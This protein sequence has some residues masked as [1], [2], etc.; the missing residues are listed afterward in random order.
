MED[1]VKVI[2]LVGRSTGGIG[3]HVAQLS[4]DLRE[5]GVDVLVVTHPL[6]AEHFDLAPVALC[7]PGSA[8]MVHSLADLRALRR[9]AATADIVHAHGH[10]GGLLATLATLS[11]HGMPGV[12]RRPKPQGPKLIVSQHNAVLDGSRWQVLKRLS[13]RWVA[14]HADLVTGASSDLVKEALTFG[15]GRAELA[16]VPSPRV[17]QLLG[18]QP[19]DA[20]ARVRIRQGMFSLLGL[21]VTDGAAP[22]V[23]TIC[24]I[25]PQKNLPVLLQAASRLRQACTWVVLG[26]GEPELLAQLRM[27]GSALGAPV[28]FVGSSSEID[29]WLRGAEVFVLPSQWEARALVVQEAMAAGTPVVAS[30]VGGLHELVLGTGLLVPA[31]DPEAI[32]KATDSILADP[33]LREQLA[34]HGREVA[35]ALPDGSDTVSRWLAWYSQTLLMT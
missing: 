19:A 33:G 31:G 13:Q 35:T 5:R 34:A 9:L 27:H 6:T 12:G 20:A 11:S 1:S 21:D 28:H 14:R 25:A 30:D 18:Q 17:P 32:A 15:A 2:M 23:L 7:W 3:T 29:T 10:Q 4:A 24:R 26:E 22:L 16:E 8:G